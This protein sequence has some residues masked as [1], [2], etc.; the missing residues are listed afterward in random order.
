MIS[1]R[2]FRLSKGKEASMTEHANYDMS[3]IDDES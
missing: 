1:N 2:T 3:L